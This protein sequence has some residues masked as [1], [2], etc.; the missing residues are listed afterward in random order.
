MYGVYA[1]AYE[2]AE[3][4]KLYDTDTFLINDTRVLNFSLQMSRKFDTLCKRF[5]VPIRDTK[6]FDHPIQNAQSRLG[7][8]RLD[9]FLSDLPNQLKL[10]R[11]LLAVNTLTTNNGDTTITAANY[12]LM[13]G[14]EHNLTP[15]D[16]IEL[17]VD[18]T[19]TTFL[20]SGTP[21]QSNS[22]DAIWGYHEDYDNAWQQLDTIQD[23][24]GINASATSVTVTD[25]DAFD[26]LG[27]KPRFQQQQLLRFGSIDTSEM[28]Y[29]SGINYSTQVLTIIRGVNGST[30][31][32][33]ANA[34]AI[35]VFR[36]QEEIKHAMLVLATHAYRR[37]D[38]VGDESDQKFAASGVIIMPPGLPKEVLDMLRTYKRPW[39]RTN[40]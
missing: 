35:E 39:I 14:Y 36:P 1:T 9:P 40:P 17:S 12:F 11:D 29:V 15:K 8:N 16:R 28:V 37:K 27:R 6:A 21:Q 13:T 3:Y 2:V 34:T 23:V 38:K 10:N 32:I 22:V 18:G 4:T 25:A 26:E 30:A 31:A 20:Y 33:Q 19:Q 7:F 5:F 24:G